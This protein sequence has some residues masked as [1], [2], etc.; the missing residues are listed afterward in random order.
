MEHISD[1]DKLVAVADIFGSSCTQGRVYAAA[2]GIHHNGT[3]TSGIKTAYRN[4]LA[5]P[6]G[7]AEQ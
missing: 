5:D 7:H 6:P 2:K 3:A 1:F 4:S